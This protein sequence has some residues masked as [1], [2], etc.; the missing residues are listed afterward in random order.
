[1]NAIKLAKRL[2]SA[3]LRDT[4]GAVTTEWVVLTAGILGLSVVVMTSIGG[5]TEDLSQD[6]LAEIEAQSAG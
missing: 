5:S 6:V 3:Y 4:S 1:M 2:V